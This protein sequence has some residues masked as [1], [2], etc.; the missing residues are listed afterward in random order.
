MDISHKDEYSEF[1]KRTSMLFRAAGLTT[2]VAVIAKVS[3]NP[4]DYPNGLYEKLI[5]VYDYDSL[6][7]S[8]DF[9]TV[10]S[11]DDP[12][13]KGPAVGWGWLNQ[14]L[15][16]SLTHT[17][18]EK[19]S[20]GLA[21]YYWSRDVSTWKLIGIGGNERIDEIIE[22]GS[23]AFTYDA[24]NRMPVMHY[25]YQGRAYSLWY[26][27]GKSM[28]HKITLIKENELRGFSAWTLGLEVP[29]TWNVFK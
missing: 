6:A 8:A 15:Q 5:G 25:V 24:V 10:M 16:Y 7:A 23:T 4:A 3:D 14:V 9:V 2:S 19:L 1:I 29:S 20:L 17:P 22:R 12:T 18:R 11:Y 13:S 27:N 28:A 26:E 21:L